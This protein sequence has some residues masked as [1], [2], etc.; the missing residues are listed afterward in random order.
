MRPFR[1]I[2]RIMDFSQEFTALVLFL[3]Q[4]GLAIAGAAA[5]W[6]LYFFINGKSGE[7]EHHDTACARLAEKMLIPYWIGFVIAF[8]GWSLKISSHWSIVAASRIG[9]LFERLSTTTQGLLAATTSLW[10]LLFILTLAGIVMHVFFRKQLFRF[11]NI[12]YIAL[13]AF[14]F[15]LI[16]FPTGI[17]QWDIDRLYFIRNGFPLIFTMGSV[18]IVDFIFFFTRPSL[19]T[20]RNIYPH[21]PNINKV[22]W[23]GLGISF[24]WEWTGLGRSQLTPQFYFV[25]TIIAIAIINGTLFTGSLT[26][27]LIAGVSERQVKPLDKWWVYVSEISSIISFSCWSTIT[28]LSFFSDLHL[29][30]W[31]LIALYVI[32]TVAVYLAFLLIEYLSDKPLSLVTTH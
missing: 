17:E 9:P 28:Y 6:G 10:V 32:K 2:F 12:Y 30:Y 11:L 1:D 8:I 18:S 29:S 27:R 13:L 25:Q 4:F 24:L 22:V 26:Q 31:F 16:S 14:C 5:M 7:G 20:K 23:I 15:I 3:Q 19:R 21:L